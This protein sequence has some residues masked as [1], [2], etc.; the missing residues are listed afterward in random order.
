MCALTS[1]ARATEHSWAQ[2]TVSGSRLAERSLSACRDFRSEAHLPRG[3]LAAPAATATAAA[4]SPRRCPLGRPVTAAAQV[5]SDRWASW[6]LCSTPPAGGGM[7]VF[8][9]ATAGNLNPGLGQGALLCHH[10]ACGNGAHGCPA[11]ASG[12]IRGKG[13]CDLAGP[14]P[15]AP[16]S[17]WQAGFRQKFFSPTSSYCE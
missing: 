6:R 10:W 11:C 1:I 7:G 4:C 3:A 13:T 17:Q 16:L 9:A 5:A 8:L 12:V 2:L 15:G 14:S